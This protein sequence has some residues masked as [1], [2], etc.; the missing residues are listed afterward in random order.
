MEPLRITARLLMSTVLSAA[1]AMAQTGWDRLQSIPPG[2]TIRVHTAKNRL[3]GAFVSASSDAV[4]LKLGDGQQISI[5]QSDVSRVDAKSSSHRGR[6]TLI[7]TAIGAGIGI[8]FY[9][10]YGQILRNEGAKGT[11]AIMMIPTA[12]GA[13]IGALLPTGRYKKI[14]DARKAR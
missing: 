7:G 13:G 12:S 9:A 10:S 4:N 8:A 6:N 5:S 14:Y 2:R 3:E 1:I 11:E